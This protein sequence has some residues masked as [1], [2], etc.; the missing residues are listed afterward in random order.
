MSNHILS[1]TL[2]HESYPTRD[3]Y[4]FSLPLFNQT[5]QIPFEYPV[6]FFVGE[7]GTGKSTL[8]EA[9][10]LACNI[11]IWRNYEGSRFQYNPYEKQLC[12]HLTIE[13]ANGKVPGSYFGSEIF[14]DFRR[15]LDNWAASDP[16]QFQYF[17]GKS[18]LEQSHGQ[19]I[20]AFFRS[21][22]RL[23]GLYF[24]DEPETALSPRTQ[25]ELLEILREF[26]KG[27]QAQFV[28]ATHSPILLAL[29]NAAIFSFDQSPAGP[30]TYKETAHY[31]IYKDFLMGR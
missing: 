14:N 3:H 11:H 4:P 12:R 20:M 30:V 29:E 28:I 7:N 9:V 22:Y 15:S 2:N 8:L 26:G 10:A 19:S 6:T 18:L 23:K 13:W 1:V 17:G 27:G 16:G 31:Q 25:I 5:S 24:L 21:R